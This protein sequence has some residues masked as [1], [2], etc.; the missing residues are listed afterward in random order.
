MAIVANFQTMTATN[1]ETGTLSAELGTAA[2]ALP[3]EIVNRYDPSVPSEEVSPCG[4]ADVSVMTSVMGEDEVRE[5]SVSAVRPRYQEL[6]EGARRDFFLIPAFKS[7][8]GEKILEPSETEHC[9]IFAEVVD[10]QPVVDRTKAMI[11]AQAFDSNNPQ[12]PASQFSARII[13]ARPISA[14]GPHGPVG[15]NELFCQRQHHRQYMLGNGLR[16][17][18]CLIEQQDASF[19]TVVDVNHIISSASGSDGQQVRAALKKIT[20]G[21][22]DFRRFRTG[23]KL[24]AMGSGQSLPIFIC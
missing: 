2:G 1:N 8:T 21:I 19:R 23:A 9:T 16:I 24:M 17:R 18:P 3:R 12:R 10:D 6:P 7:V 4:F 13:P 22:V 20:T 11:V 14:A 5:Q 15:L